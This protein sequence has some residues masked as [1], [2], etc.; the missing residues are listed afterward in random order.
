M[1]RADDGRTMETQRKDVVTPKM[2]FFTLILDMFEGQKKR[3]REQR[4]I[5]A[6]NIMLEINLVS[7]MD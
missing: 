5:Y 4:D 1:N 3:L 6:E 2:F 7:M